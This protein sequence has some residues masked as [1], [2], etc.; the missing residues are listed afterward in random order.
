MH[1]HDSR[2]VFVVEATFN[3]TDSEVQ[4]IKCRWM[5]SRPVET[6]SDC[7]RPDHVEAYMKVMDDRGGVET[8]LLALRRRSSLLRSRP[9]G[10]GR[11]LDLA[12]PRVARS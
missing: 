9:D 2:G 4:V 12:E 7:R 10:S 8:S 3:V 6:A 1:W 11:W 5:T